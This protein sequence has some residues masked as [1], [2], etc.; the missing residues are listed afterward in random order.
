[1]LEAAC[2]FLQNAGHPRICVI[3]DLMLDR[4]VWGD[5]ARI[6]QEGPI[7]V[8]RVQTTEH[9]PGG[10]GSVASMLRSL[11]CEVLLVGLVGTDAAGESLQA[12]LH[13]AGIDVSG[14]VRSSARPTATKTRFLGYVQSAGRALQQLLRVD[15]EDTAPLSTEE[16]AQVRRAAL[17]KADECDLLVLQDMGKGL[18][19]PALLR[20][21][22]GHTQ[23]SGKQVVVDPERTDDYAPYSG[24]TCVLPNRFE[25]QTATGLPMAGEDD[26][27]RAARRL[28]EELSLDCAAIKL[29]REGIY[30]ATADGQEKHVTTQA[31]QVAD[32]TGAGDMVTAAT[33]LALAEGAD[34]PTAFALANFA[35][36][37]EVG[38]H[39][40]TPV[41]RWQVLE[42]MRAETDPTS[43]KIRSR[44][45]IERLAAD[46]RSAG[47]K[48]AFT[49]GCFDLLHLGHVELIR[50]ARAQGDVLIV[51]LNSDGSARRLKGPGRP[52]NSE[53]VRSRVL[54]SLADVDYVVLF[55]ETSVLPLIQQ[56]RPDVLV[57]GGDYGHDEVVGHEFVESCGGQVKLAPAVKGLSTTELINRIAGRNERADRGD[58]AQ[59]RQ[60]PRKPDRADPRY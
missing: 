20:E 34:Y 43:R 49:N 46:L 59:G 4:Y 50:Y 45:E 57:K 48:I 23:A 44:K 25:A 33:A 37:I 26:Y 14:L 8:L 36:G 5:V 47:K 53:Q 11:E 41:P 19:D 38:L 6:S 9:R 7:P 29:D 28:L 42:A 2:E 40:V 15:Q 54:A 27:R 21:L 30:F 12:A 51:G 58:A 56:V 3:G 55:D 39:G 24:A 22:I 16:S 35:A 13:D 17:A 1:M 31:R 52:I 60:R 32:V 10:A 18:F